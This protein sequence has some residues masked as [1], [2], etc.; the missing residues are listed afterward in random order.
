MPINPYIAGEIFRASR[1]P[2]IGLRGDIRREEEEEFRLEQ[3]R[4]RGV[5][6]KER[7]RE[8]KRGQG[9][10]LGGVP[11]GIL[12]FILGG[13]PGA[14]IGAGIGSR[15]GQEAMVRTSPQ[16]MRKFERIGPGKYYVSRGREREKQ[17]EYGQQEQDRYFK[18]LMLTS[19]AM[20]AISGY[21]GAKYGG[22]ILD[23]ILGGT[24]AQRASD[25]ARNLGIFQQSMGRRTPSATLFYGE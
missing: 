17:F 19:A 10:W 25:P 3:E 8:Q 16:A 2:F 11:G 20:D 22:G 4:L 18:E 7:R 15:V 24:P 9:R 12:G 5:G 14:A 21:T 1:E 6:T 13:P 23:M